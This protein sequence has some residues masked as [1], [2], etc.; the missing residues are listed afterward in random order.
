MNFVE[1]LENETN[2]GYTENSGIK[3]KSTL[4]VVLDMF[5]MGGAMRNRTDADIIDMF[6]TLGYA[7]PQVYSYSSLQTRFP[8]SLGRL[9]CMVGE[10][11]TSGHIWV[12]DG[13]KYYH[14]VITNHATEP[15]TVTDSDRY[16]NHV[17][18]GWNG[19]SNG[20]FLDG[21]FT[22]NAAYSYD[23]ESLGIASNSYSDIEYFT[24]KM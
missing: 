18:W 22:A 6:E 13:F 5:A 11:L 23:D 3:H 24:I 17:N 12:V 4:N 21:V 10:S 19:I 7:R 20:Y 1:A 16:Y 15:A 8:L 2:Y 9:I 14:D